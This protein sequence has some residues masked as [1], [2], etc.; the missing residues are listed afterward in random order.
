M[1]TQLPAIYIIFIF[2][3]T[4]LAAAGFFLYALWTAHRKRTYIYLSALLLGVWMYFQGYLAA[5]GFYTTFDGKPRFLLAIGPVLLLIILVFIFRRSRN[6]LVTISLPVLTLLSVV[7]IPVEF[8]IDWWYHAGLVPQLMTFEG[9][10][11]DIISG[12]T[13]PIVFFL[14]FRTNKGRTNRV[15]LIVWNIVCLL[16]LVNIVTNAILSVPGPAQMQAF[17]Q[18]AVAVLHYPFVWLPSVIVPAVLFSHLVSL[19]QLLFNKRE[20]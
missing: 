5:S 8:V 1:M 3:L 15:L 12:V 20:W 11:F 6:A 17:D 4:V 19:Y 13:A 7:R 16:L 14:A 10:N 9:R 2:I 18:P